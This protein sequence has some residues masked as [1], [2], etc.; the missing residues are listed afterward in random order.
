MQVFQI[1][2]FPSSYPILYGYQ[3]INFCKFFI[4]MVFI[5]MFSSSKY[6][7]ISQCIYGSVLNYFRYCSMENS[8]VLRETVENISSNFAWDRPDCHLG[9]INFV[10][11]SKFPILSFSIWTIVWISDILYILKFMT[12]SYWII[13]FLISRIYYFTFG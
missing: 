7:E 8:S 12:Y 3:G 10:I 11:G 13:W 4:F 9:L 1:V 6:F 5:F 2:I